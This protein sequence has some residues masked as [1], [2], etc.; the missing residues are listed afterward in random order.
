MVKKKKWM[1]FCIFWTQVRTRVM[2]MTF[3]G[4]VARSS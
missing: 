1:S 3:M 4:M 2:T